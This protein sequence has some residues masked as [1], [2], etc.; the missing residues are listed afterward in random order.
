MRYVRGYDSDKVLLFVD[1]YRNTGG[2]SKENFGWEFEVHADFDTNF[3]AMEQMTSWGITMVAHYMAKNSD[4]LPGMHGTSA[5]ATP[6]RFVDADWILD[7]LRE[8]GV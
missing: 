2:M 7:G 8:R 1:A 4:S 3:S 6:D 5:F